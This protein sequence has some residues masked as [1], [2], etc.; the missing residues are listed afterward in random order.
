[1]TQY[2]SYDPFSVCFNI[3]KMKYADYDESLTSKN[4]LNQYDKINVFINLETVFKNISMIQDLEKKIVIQ[5][6]FD[7]LMVS[8]ILNLVAHYKRFFVNNTFDTRVYIYNT[9]L[10]SDEFNQYK[11]NEDFRSYYLTKYNAN[12]KFVLLSERL[13]NSILPD[14][15]T[16]CEFIPGVYYVSAKNIEGSLVPYI[17]GM[18]DK[19]RKNIIIGGELYDTQ[20]S[21]IPNFINHYIHKSFNVNT[22][23]SDLLGYIKDI[24]KKDNED[25]I[26][27]LNTYNSYSTY[28]ALM[29][30]LGDKAR[31]IDSISGYGVSTLQKCIDVGKMQNI[32]QD[33]TTS[34]ELIGNIFHDGEIKKDF[35]NNYYCSSILNM[36]DELTEAEK[37]FI[38]N[39][40]T[41]DRDDKNSF[42]SLNRT[43]FYNHNLIL[44][45]L[46]I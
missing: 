20:Y 38:L 36:Y 28:C 24:S 17:I 42:A 35:V 12:P 11:Y 41:I 14:V 45:G 2:A 9:D 32:I 37:K 43:K 30:V 23:N 44:E 16:Y 46:L 18:S 4:L 7:V 40:I 29:S 34:P 5:R 1:M 31:S 15:R 6:D 19:S 33:G 25:L 13:K 39:Q 26:S 10:D 3:L 22:V 27:L 21:I 8:N